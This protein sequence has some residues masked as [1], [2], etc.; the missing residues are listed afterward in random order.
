[1][2]VDLRISIKDYPRREN[3]KLP[4]FL[5]H[6]SRAFR[7]SLAKSGESLAMPSCFGLVR[8]CGIPR[9]RDAARRGRHEF[10]P[11]GSGRDCIFNIPRKGRAG[12][13]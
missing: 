11:D 9:G 10:A 5:C 7:K 4:N 1:M 13:K 12:G 2:K 8:T 6:L 3:V